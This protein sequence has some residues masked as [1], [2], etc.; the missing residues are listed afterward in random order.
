MY[1]NLY[2]QVASGTMEAFSS[3][4]GHNA[5]SEMGAVVVAFLTVVA[6]MVLQLAIV[7]WLW[8][9]CLTRVVSIAKPMASMFDALGLIVLFMFLWP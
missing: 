9:S 6:I 7:Q 3:G 5:S 8:N 1:T 2:K 4:S